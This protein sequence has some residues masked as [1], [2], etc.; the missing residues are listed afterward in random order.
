M[1][2]HT[3]SAESALEALLGRIAD[4][5]AERWRRGEAPDADEYAR[6]HP[7]I[8]DLLREILPALRAFEALPPS[9]RRAA[10]PPWQEGQAE[11]AP[12][13]PAAPWPPVAGRFEV[14]EKLG[15]G[16]MGVV[17]KARQLAL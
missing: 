4:E 5:F 3:P 15:E 6:L 16:G 14:L 12:D 13:L 11:G 1:T 8:A 7:E 17:Y 9:V 10:T 2:S